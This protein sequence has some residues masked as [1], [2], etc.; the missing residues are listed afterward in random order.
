MTNRRKDRYLSK[1]KDFDIFN[2]SK[3]ELEKKIKKSEK[4]FEEKRFIDAYSLLKKYQ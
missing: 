4:D 2:P 3:E 1:V